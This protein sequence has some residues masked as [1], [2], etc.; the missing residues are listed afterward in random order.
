MALFAI[1]SSPFTNPQLAIIHGIVQHC[2]AFFPSAGPLTF[3][4]FFGCKFLLSGPTLIKNVKSTSFIVCWYGWVFFLWKSRLEKMAYFQY[5]RRRRRRAYAPTSNTASHDTHEKINSWVSFC[6]LIWVWGSAW[7]P[8]AAG[9]PLK[10]W[11]LFKRSDDNS[12][13]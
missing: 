8:S 13:R 12:K 7:L 11:S 10:R 1:I 9:A 4:Y 3:R 5:K 6:S 2:F